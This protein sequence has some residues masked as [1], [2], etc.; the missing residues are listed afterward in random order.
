M[1][2]L[3][4]ILAVEQELKGRKEKAISRAWDLFQNHTQDFKGGIK[5]L[6]M[7]DE[8]RSSEE[9]A[10]EERI[11]VIA[12]VNGILT[13][14]FSDVSDFWDG[15]LQKEASNQLAVADIIVDGKTIAEHVPVT[16]LLSMED[17]LKQLRMMLE[18]IPVLDSAMAWEKNPQ[19]GEF[20]WKTSQSIVR[21]KTEQTVQHKILVPA[22]DNGG[23]PA[24][25]QVWNENVPVGKYTSITFSGMLPENEKRKMLVKVSTLLN[26]VKKARQRANCQEVEDRHIGIKLLGFILS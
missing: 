13:E 20:F 5:T 15:R 10:G 17:E 23:H 3:H 25:V 2:K 7:F 22:K 1:A 6:E 14:V 26:A 12:S 19:K 21:N 4:E 16:F 24:Q 8:S 9:A 11:E 18:K